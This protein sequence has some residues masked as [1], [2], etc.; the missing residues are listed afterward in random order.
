MVTAKKEFK[1]V[2]SSYEKGC[3]EYITK[4]VTPEKLKHVLGELG[5]K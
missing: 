4:P 3:S 1:E 5:I 2:S